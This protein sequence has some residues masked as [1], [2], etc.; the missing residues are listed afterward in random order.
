M[1]HGTKKFI[2]KLLISLIFLLALLTTAIL[3]FSTLYPIGYKDYINKYS[4]EYGIDPFL[5]AAIINVESKYNKNA[6]SPKEA[7]GL[8]QIGT[9]TGK[10]ASEELEIESYRED[11]LFDPETNIKIGTWYINRLNK[12]FNGNLD[13]VLAAYNAGSGNVSKWLENKNYSKDNINLHKIPFKET[14]NYLKRVKTNYKI[15]KILYKHHMSKPDNM[16]S[17]YIDFINILRDY[18]KNI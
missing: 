18:I 13:L 5:V 10:W 16:N 2:F 1:L 8:M 4:K 11:M 17:V 15:Y 12:E 6:V 9:Q 3:I 14:E 7:K